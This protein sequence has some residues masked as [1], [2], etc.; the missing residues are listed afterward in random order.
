MYRSD[1]A[2]NLVYG[3][4]SYSRVSTDAWPRYQDVVKVLFMALVSAVLLTTQKRMRYF[5]IVVALSLAFYGIKGGLFSFANG[6]EY[7]VGGAG[8]STVAGN[9]ATG[10]ALNMC[11]PFL[12]YLAYEEQGWLRKLLQGSFFLSIPAIMFTYSRASLV[13]LGIILVVLIL[14]GGRS[15]LLLVV[16]LIIGGTLA[17]PFIPAKWFNRQESTLSYEEDGS[18]M[19]RIDNWKICWQVALD[20]PITGAGFEFQTTDFYAKYSPEYIARYGKAFN[21]HS[22]YFAMLATHGFPGFFIFV[23]VIIFT[24]NSCRRMRRSVKRRP[25][26]KWIANYCNIVTV[27][28]LAFLIN[29]AFVNMEYLTC[30]TISWR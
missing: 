8:T 1:A 18:A 14:K 17:I 13:T 4:S 15:S 7:M 27:S 5:L 6:G 30:R 28:M 25:D 19:S 26:L 11:L 24:W 3:I 29:G 9:N 22:I 21:T 12:W 10:L 16:G 23:A 2:G 20:H